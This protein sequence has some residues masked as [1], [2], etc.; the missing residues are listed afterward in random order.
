RPQCLLGLLRQRFAQ[1][2]SAQ[3]GDRADRLVPGEHGDG[4]RGAVAHDATLGEGAPRQTLA[5]LHRDDALVG[6]A[7]DHGHGEAAVALV[8]EGD[9]GGARAKETVDDGEGFLQRFG[10]FLFLGDGAYGTRHRQ[11]GHHGYSS[12]P[13]RVEPRRVWS[14]WRSKSKRRDSEALKRGGSRG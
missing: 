1:P 10:N 14:S 8:V 12:K 2:R 7:A 5:R 6:A 9:E 4:Q 11:L 3:A 13:P